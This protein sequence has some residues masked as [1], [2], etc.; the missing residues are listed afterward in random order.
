[1]AHALEEE[2]PRLLRLPKHPFACD[3]VKPIRSEKTPY[4]RFD[5]NDYSIPHTLVRKPLTL[6]ASHTTLRLLDGEAEVARHPRCWDK[7]RQIESEI[8][9]AGV[10]LDPVLPDDPRVRDLV[11][12]PHRL[13]SYD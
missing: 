3:L 10:P 12:L 13:D 1:V 2:R 7:Q 8:H 9:L 6:V 11:I 4:V 5:G